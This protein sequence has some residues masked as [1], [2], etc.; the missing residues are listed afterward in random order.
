MTEENQPETPRPAVDFLKAVPILDVP[1]KY[2][3]LLRLGTP[4]KMTPPD[5]PLAKGK[6]LFE[7]LRIQGSLA[8]RAEEM[9]QH[10]EREGVMNYNMHL[11]AE[12]V[13][14]FF[15][16][17]YDLNIARMV[18]M[19]NKTYEVGLSPNNPDASL[20]EVVMVMCA[21]QQ[22]FEMSGL[23]EDVELRLDV[24]NRKIIATAANRRALVDLV[25][26]Q[27]DITPT[28]LAL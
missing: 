1:Q 15:A 27:Y 4:I 16:S 8:A 17:K 13:D 6:F 24:S 12:V 7:Y 23:A 5:H 28:I 10:L 2:E 19:P 26:D 3:H 25:G 11:K 21:F 22:Q 18:F 9:Q 20:E 14:F